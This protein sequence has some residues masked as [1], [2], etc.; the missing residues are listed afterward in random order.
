MSAA[1]STNQPDLDLLAA[2]LHSDR[3]HL[4][5][6]VRSSPVCTVGERYIGDHQ[7]EPGFVEVALLAPA[8][9]RATSP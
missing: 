2:A 5:T 8:V 4:Q 3:S 6:D 7:N 9:S 1:E